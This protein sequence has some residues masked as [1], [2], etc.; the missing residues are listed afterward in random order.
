MFIFL[1]SCQ[2][3]IKSGHIRQK[4]QESDLM[5]VNANGF[6]YDY[7]ENRKVDI[8]YY[9]SIKFKDINK[10]IGNYIIVSFQ[11]PEKP[12]KFY[13][14]TLPITKDDNIMY[15]ESNKMYG[16]KNMGAYLTKVE[17][18]NNNGGDVVLDSIEQYNRVE[19]IPYGYKN[20]M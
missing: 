13:S 3:M 4:R 11:D 18:V 6:L 15:I 9:I 10:V 7:R 2:S 14:Q 5:L 16:F 19:Y 17:L 8:K 1:F 12:D 20:K